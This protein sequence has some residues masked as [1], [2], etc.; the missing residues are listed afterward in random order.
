M[1][2]RTVLTFG[3]NTPVQAQ[4]YFR[5]CNYYSQ[6]KI[7]FRYRPQSCNGLLQKFARSKNSAHNLSIAHNKNEIKIT[8]HNVPQRSKYL[9]L[10]G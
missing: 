6:S 2:R 8:H 10:I 9:N 3:N 1:F 5:S 7:T 4:H